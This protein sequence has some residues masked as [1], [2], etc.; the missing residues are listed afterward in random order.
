[1]RGEVPKKTILVTPWWP[2]WPLGKVGQYLLWGETTQYRHLHKRRGKNRLVGGWCL[3]WIDF[4][5]WLF[6]AYYQ[7]IPLEF[8][9]SI[10]TS[11]RKSNYSFFSQSTLVEKNLEFCIENQVPSLIWVKALFLYLNFCQC[12][13]ILVVDWGVKIILLSLGLQ[14]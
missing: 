1:M 5:N 6:S 11:T 13:L 7:L 2:N 10:I 3:W 12:F 8:L 14:A 9:Q 4:S